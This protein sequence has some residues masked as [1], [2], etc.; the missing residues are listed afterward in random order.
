MVSGSLLSLLT[1]LTFFGF[2]LSQ[3]QLVDCMYYCEN[4]TRTK[5]EQ[6][7]YRIFLCPSLTLVKADLAESMRDARKEKKKKEISMKTKMPRHRKVA[8]AAVVAFIAFAA[9]VAFIAFIAAFVVT[10]TT[11]LS[12]KL[13]Q[14]TSIFADL[15]ISAR[16]KKNRKAETKLDLASLVLYSALPLLYHLLL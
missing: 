13:G 9:V 14:L 1:F 8:F 6:K 10:D 4:K 7:K 5:R 2:S 16:R 11:L 15:G 3:T 12:F